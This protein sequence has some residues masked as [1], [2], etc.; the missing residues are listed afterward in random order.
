LKKLSIDEANR[1]AAPS[2]S[3]ILRFIA[4]AIFGP[5][6]TLSAA[7]SARVAIVPPR[8]NP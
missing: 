1:C 6:K 2:A 8:L 7:A 4:P 5:A 3:T